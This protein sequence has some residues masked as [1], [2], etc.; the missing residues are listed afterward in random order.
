MYK[1][2][3][4]ITIVSFLIHTSYAQEEK[5][6]TRPNII[7]I[8]PNRLGADQL[9]QY[10]GL[11]HKTPNIDYLA[12]N[13]ITFYYFTARYNT[14][15]SWRGLITGVSDAEKGSF[16]RFMWLRNIGYNLIKELNDV[17]YETCFVGKWRWPGGNGSNVETAVNPDSG[18][19]NL[20]RTQF[21]HYWGLVTA[22][23]VDG[24]EFAYAEN[25]SNPYYD[26]DQVFNS[27]TINSKGT[28]DKY[29]PHNS[30]KYIENFIDYAHTKK[31]PFYIW[32]SM[33]YMYTHS[34]N[35]YPP[36]PD[37]K[38]TTNQDQIYYANIRYMDKM[39][40]RLIKTL[41]KHKIL[42]NT[43]ILFASLSGTPQ[44]TEGGK[45]VKG[46]Y[47]GKISYGVNVYRHPI[48]RSNKEPLLKQF[49]L[50]QNYRTPFIAFWPRYIKEKRVDAS[51]VSIEDLQITIAKL[52][53]AKGINAYIN[54]RPSFRSFSIIPILKGHKNKGAKRLVTYMF[55]Q[56]RLSEGP[57]TSPT[58]IFAQNRNYKLYSNG[59]FYNI[60]NDPEE[61]KVLKRLTPLEK[62]IKKQLQHF[63]NIN[64]SE[65]PPA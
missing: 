27:N 23:G 56:P 14:S 15:S 59:D 26:K 4:F 44:K 61:K 3:L 58:Y 30:I 10:G 2:L 22:I 54:T 11:S 48:T 16:A 32:W 52:T 41:Q 20:G 46:I 63:I 34:S 33:I 62:A 53:H 13:G 1:N 35:W 39:I 18:F 38:S 9:K 51:L 64:P 43:L 17:G 21:K 5:V 60:A 6:D 45:G 36:T 42:N 55:L 19:Y 40:G 50:E 28:N 8:T 24:T 65:R 25:P 31:K 49:T 37:Y 47:R 29:N 12:D 7:L 57:N